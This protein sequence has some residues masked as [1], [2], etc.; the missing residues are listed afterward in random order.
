MDG[1]QV[2][3]K[4]VYSIEANAELKEQ[5]NSKRHYITLAG[6]NIAQTTNE[7]V[8]A[9]YSLTMNGTELGQVKFNDPE[10]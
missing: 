4:P 7:G 10:F 1:D 5:L 6:M 2:T 3:V 9:L 8:M